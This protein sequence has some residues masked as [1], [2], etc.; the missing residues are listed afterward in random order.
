VV[1][2]NLTHLLRGPASLPLAAKNQKSGVHTLA[3]S[4]SLSLE[5]S[6]QTH[7]EALHTGRIRENKRERESVV[8]YLPFD[9]VS[10]SS[11]PPHPPFVSFLPSI[12]GPI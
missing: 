10:T 6:A 7:R 9:L 12:F 8:V 1:W 5:T 11:P 2:C 3:G 4:L